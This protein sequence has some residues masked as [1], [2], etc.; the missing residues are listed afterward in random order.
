MGERADDSIQTSEAG[1]SCRLVPKGSGL[2][3]G[4]EEGAK[5]SDSVI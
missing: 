3:Q 2:E 5:V 4:A 1:R